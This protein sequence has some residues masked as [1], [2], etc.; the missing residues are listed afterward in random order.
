MSEHGVNRL[1]VMK[2]EELVGIVTRTDLVR[3]F[4]RSDAEIR[5]EIEGTCSVAHSGSRRRT[6]WSSRS[7][8]A[9]FA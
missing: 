4:I 5:E 7:S 9:P 1:P 8:A 2:G 6:W 3:A